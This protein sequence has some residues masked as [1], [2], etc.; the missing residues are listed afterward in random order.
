MSNGQSLQGVLD[1]I[2]LVWPDL[3]DEDCNPLDIVLPLLNNKSISPTIDEF[4]ELK[5]QFTRS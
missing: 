2:N 1:R 3:L 4:E 5:S